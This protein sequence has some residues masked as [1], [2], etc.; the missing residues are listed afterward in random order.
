[1]AIL[2]LLIL[3]TLLLWNVRASQSLLEVANRLQALRFTLVA[4]FPWLLLTVL[5]V[6][7]F[8]CLL[9]SSLHLQLTDLLRFK[10]AILLL[11]WEWVRVR[12]LF[13]V[14]MDI[15]LTHFDLDLKLKTLSSSNTYLQ[16]F[17]LHTFL[18]ML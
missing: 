4:D 3:G 5:G 7:V 1:M 8:L 15:S 10:V 13:A 14:S 2:L 16:E 6:T 18:G 9:R 17:D 11:N 12:E